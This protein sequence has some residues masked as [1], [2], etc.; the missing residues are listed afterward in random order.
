MYEVNQ[1]GEVFNTSTRE[2][3]SVDMVGFLAKSSIDLFTND[4]TV[5][6]RN[7]N[8]ESRVTG[9]SIPEVKKLCRKTKY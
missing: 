4:G 8:Y 6:D 3:V 7:L 5:F 9:L 2:V 1:K